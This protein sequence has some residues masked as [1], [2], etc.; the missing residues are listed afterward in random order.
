MSMKGSVITMR[1][2]CG[3]LVLTAVLCVVA[4]RT[5][6][7]AT[8]KSA[9][10][11]AVLVYEQQAEEEQIEAIAAPNIPVEAAPFVGRFSVP[12]VSVDVACYDSA[13]QATVDAADSAAYFFSCGHTI[14]GDHVN[15]GFS[16]I[17]SCSVG[18]TACLK[19]ENGEARY[20]CVDV[21]QGHNTGTAL[22]D[23]AYCS[24]EN[25]YP[26]ALVCYTC[27]ENWQ[28]VTLVF[29]VPDSGDTPVVTTR[30]HSCAAD[31]HEWGTAFSGWEP[32]YLEDGSLRDYVY[33][34][35]RRCAVCGF[36]A[37]QAVCDFGI[38]D[39]E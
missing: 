24:I 11:A 12:S 17:K 22:T 36:E 14:I 35:T 30:P 25:L 37:R 4:P 13:S 1:V 39:I 28:N 34:E 29:F 33:Y 9:D 2:L 19:T 21:I 6:R 20:T 10:S 38:Y 18:T 27:N 16:A 31:G 7:A 26:G 32:D 8:A 15:Q 5:S 23:A 3:L